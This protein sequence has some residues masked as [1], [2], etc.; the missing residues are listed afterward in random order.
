MIS[1]KQL[2]QHTGISEKDLQEAIGGSWG[3]G[4]GLVPDDN[5]KQKN[6]DNSESYTA[7]SLR[8]LQRIANDN[9]KEWHNIA[10]RL[11]SFERIFAKGHGYLLLADYKVIK[12]MLEKQTTETD[13]RIEKYL[14][15]LEQHVR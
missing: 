6:R 5:Y 3:G 8:G 1:L 11:D 13:R 15:M 7:S 14:R 12:K 9:R 2:M 10:K 4:S